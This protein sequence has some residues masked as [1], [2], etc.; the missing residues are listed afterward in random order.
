[1]ARCQRFLQ[2]RKESTPT[3][4]GQAEGAEGQTPGEVTRPTRA[5]PALSPAGNVAAE[6]AAVLPIGGDAGG[7][8]VVEETF[9]NL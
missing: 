4:E 1:L 3:R 7:V 5:A 6:P 9:G 8:P 2:Q